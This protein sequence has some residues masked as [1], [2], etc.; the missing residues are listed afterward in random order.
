MA[1][2]GVSE[3]LAEHEAMSTASHRRHAT[4]ARCALRAGC[5]Q[6]L[7]LYLPE[8]ADGVLGLQRDL[9]VVGS[10]VRAVVDH[11]AVDP[12]LDLVSTAFDHH[13]VPLAR[14]LLARV[15]QVLDAALAAVDAPFRLRSASRLHVGHRDVLADAPEVARVARVQLALDRLREHLAEPARRRSVHED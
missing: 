11:V 4:P 8:L 2:A 15:R 5:R 9:T 3:E 12:D 6:R 14:G 1:I 13:L 7:Q 10:A